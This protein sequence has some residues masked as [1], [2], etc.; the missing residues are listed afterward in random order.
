M[1]KVLIVDDDHDILSLV[2]MILSMNNF[3]VQAISQW[4]QIDN[5]ITSFSPDIILLDVSLNGA[6][7][8]DICKRLKTDST[9]KNIPIVLFSAH[10]D[11]AT[12]L[13]DCNAQG[14]IAKPF[15]IENLV[16][17]LQSAVG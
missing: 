5:S 8:R 7:G 1:K 12:S 10:A 11:V 13:Q 3:G 17:T 4:Q 2:E 15:G 16:T 9:T 6:D 14:F